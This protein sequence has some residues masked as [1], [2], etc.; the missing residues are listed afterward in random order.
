MTSPASLAMSRTRCVVLA[1]FAAL[2]ALVLW[3]RWSGTGRRASLPG[4]SVSEGSVRTNTH[5]P[6]DA[7]HRF[8]TSHSESS[9]I[10]SAERSQS[11]V[12]SP[13][14]FLAMVFEE[15]DEPLADDVLQRLEALLTETKDTTTRLRIAALLHRY[16]RQTGTEELLR[17]GASDA[18]LGDRALEVLVRSRTEKALPLV[19]RH[20]AS[21]EMGGGFLDAIGT[22]PNPE[23]V[24]AL[25]AQRVSEYGSNSLLAKALVRLGDVEA[26]AGATPE[27]RDWPSQALDAQALA[28][29]ASGS[30][31]SE[32][33]RVLANGLKAGS[34]MDARMLTGASRLAGAAAARGG[35][36]QYVHEYADRLAQWNQD[37]QTLVDDIRAG[38]REWSAPQ[39]DT[40]PYEL[41]MDGASLLAEW[42]PHPGAADAVSSLLQTYLG[43]RRTPANVERLVVALVT[44]DPSGADERLQA[45]GI[46]RETTMQARRLSQLHP[47][48][49]ALLPQQLG[50]RAPIQL[51]D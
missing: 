46:D 8:A 45:F 22:W 9:N 51:P 36:E 29:R 21:D 7:F 49:E 35:L 33:A 26:M 24:A 38:R 28:A 10:S 4:A 17:L 37:Y 20:L 43:G 47:L 50:K 40:E 6:S 23:I 15:Y 19:L 42:G 48:P 14:M 18:L 39:F 16:H 1:L 2:I 31:D 44:L 34:G 30:N 5:V 11:S 12:S 3:V 41:A 25:R 27:S 13:E 32:W